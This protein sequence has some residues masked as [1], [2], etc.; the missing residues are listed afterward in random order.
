M[1][2]LHSHSVKYT[3]ALT[4]MKKLKEDNSSNP[5]LKSTIENYIDYITSMELISKNDYE[6]ARSSMLNI[7]GRLPNN[8]M[9]VNNIAVLDILSNKVDDGFNAML[10]V[11]GKSKMNSMNDITYSNMVTVSDMFGKKIIVD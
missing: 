3:K 7:G 1:S 8:A 9:L 5:S 11:V 6:K 4:Q 2:I 10:N